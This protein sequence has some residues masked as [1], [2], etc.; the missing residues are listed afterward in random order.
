[1]VKDV[2]GLPKDVADVAGEQRPRG[3]TVDV[4]RSAAVQRVC[5]LVREK[6]LKSR[7]QVFGVGC[8]LV[9]TS[10]A[11]KHTDGKIKSYINLSKIKDY[12]IKQH[13]P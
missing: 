1:V 12:Y 6:A 13:S 10:S 9:L 5:S 3:R 7:R 11:R 4:Q 8:S 2:V